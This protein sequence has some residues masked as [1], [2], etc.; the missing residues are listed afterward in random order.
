MASQRWAS[1]TDAEAFFGDS[2][3]GLAVFWRV[4]DVIAGFGGA[5]LRVAKTQ[6]GWARRRGFAFLWCPRAELGHG[7]EVVLSLA[8]LRRDPSPRWKQ[9]AEPRPGLF[10]HHLELTSVG[11]I[12]AEVA[13]WLGQAHSDAQ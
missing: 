9:I 6:V 11:D 7:A 4:Q 8:L 13:A 1:V 2:D 10:M 3:L 5:E 12:D